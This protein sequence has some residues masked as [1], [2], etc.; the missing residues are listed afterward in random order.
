MWLDQAM[1]FKRADSLEAIA[2][3]LA[4]IKLSCEQRGWLKLFDDHVVA[5]HFFCRFLNAAFNLG[6]VELDLIQS[7]HPA[8]DLGDSTNRIAY[9]ITT[10]RRGE[11]IQHTLDKFVQ[12]GLAEQY[13]TLRILIVGDRQSTYKSVIVPVS[14]QFDSDRDILGIEELVKYIANVDTARLE[15]LRSILAD[16]LKEPI[17]AQTRHQKISPTAEELEILLKTADSREGVIHYIKYAGGFQL[18]TGTQQLI[19]DHNSRL[20]A[21][22]QAAFDRLLQMGLLKD[23][24]H[25]GERFHLSPEGFDAVDQIRQQQGGTGP[26]YAELEKDMH[27]LLGEMSADLKANPLIREFLISRVISTMAAGSLFTTERAMTNSILTQLPQFDAFFDDFSHIL[28]R[29]SLSFLAR[30]GREPM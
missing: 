23:N 21:R 18:L 26:E 24:E 2:D 22:W 16:E 19:T 12:H 7:N 8:I 1:V 3:G 4:W 10:E 11:K 17:P 20:V 13:D 29:K 6:L 15:Y 25:N 9:Q 5:Q 14:L 27:E 30:S 28:R